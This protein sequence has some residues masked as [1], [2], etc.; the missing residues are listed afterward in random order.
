MRARL[1]SQKIE[2]MELVRSGAWVCCNV[3][4]L[5]VM[6]VKQYDII[7]IFQSKWGIFAFFYTV[8]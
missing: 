5:S 3:L 2:A 1:S 6:T 7:A 8:K 4:M